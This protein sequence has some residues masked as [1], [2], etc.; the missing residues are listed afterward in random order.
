MDTKKL[1]IRYYINTDLKP[2]VKDGRELFKLYVQL[3]YDSKSTKVKIEN[4]YR[5]NVLLDPTNPNDVDMVNQLNE[6]SEKVRQQY[7][8]CDIT[9]LLKYEQD[10]ILKRFRVQGIGERMKWIYLSDLTDHIQSAI[11]LVKFMKK[12]AQDK[13]GEFLL[14]EENY[15]DLFLAYHY[16]SLYELDLKEIL[17]EKIAHHLVIETLLMIYKLENQKA[18]RPIMPTYNWIDGELRDSFLYFFRQFDTAILSNPSMKQFSFVF[19]DYPLSFNDLE[20]HAIEIDNIV[21]EK[22][23]WMY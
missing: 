20:S 7:D 19:D 1:T 21:E 10:I 3:T 17:P 9:K 16:A 14:K 12:H 15:P 4:Y 18:D 11:S 5:E 22:V 23:R 2:E 6:G 8:I 13:G